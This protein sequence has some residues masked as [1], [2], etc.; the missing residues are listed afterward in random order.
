MNTTAI[1]VLAAGASRRMHGRDKL[2]EDVDGVPLLRRSV[3]RAI[4]TGCNVLVALPAAPHARYAALEELDVA[5]IPVPDAAEGMNASLRA[6]LRA[7]SDSARAVMVLLADMPDITTDDMIT[8][9]QAVDPLSKM[10]IW[11][12]VTRK[13]EAGHPVV[14]HREVLPE[15]LALTGDQGGGAVAKAY[16]N[17]TVEIPLPDA[18][19]R[20][21]L[22]TPEAW[23]KWRAEQGAT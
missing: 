10:R 20:T 21:D 14:F 1:V 8:V 22:D 15:L 17:R 6:G 7:V 3:M 23:A 2:M 12:A 16:H 4:A 5:T 18:H 11:R 13:G 19:A 9:L